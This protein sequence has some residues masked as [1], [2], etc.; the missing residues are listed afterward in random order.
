[1]RS[2]SRQQAYV[3]ALLELDSEKLP[4]PIAAAE[5]AIVARTHAVVT[6]PD[7][8]IE[9]RAQHDALDACSQR[10]KLNSP[11]WRPKQLARSRTVIRPVGQNSEFGN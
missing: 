1:M 10:D 4:V 8:N 3:V 2:V 9:R 6:E 7:A 5:T 11:D